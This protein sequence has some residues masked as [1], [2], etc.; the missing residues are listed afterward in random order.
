MYIDKDQWT[1]DDKS[2]NNKFSQIK[3]NQWITPL[4][5]MFEKIR[6]PGRAK[7][8]F[9]YIIFALICLVFVFLG[10][11]I[12]S[13][14]GIGGFAAVVNREGIPIIE[15][16]KR[17][18]QIQKSDQTPPDAKSQKAKLGE[19]SRVVMNQL[20][21]E[22][23]I[24]QQARGSGLA[25]SNHEVR[26]KVTSFELFQ[27][28]GVFKTALYLTFLDNQRLRAKDFEDQMRKWILTSRMERLFH[29]V[30][31]VSDLERE[32]NKELDRVQIQLKYVR[33]ALLNDS[34]VQ[35]WQDLLQ[36]PV[37]LE[38]E[39]KSKKLK[40]IDS[41]KVSLRNWNRALPVAVNEKELFQQVLGVIPH[42]G[43]IPKLFL[44]KNH[45]II[46]SLKNFKISKKKMVQSS[47]ESMDSFLS[48]AYSRM[49][50][51]SWLEFVK[52]QSRIRINT[53]ILNSS[54]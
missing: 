18:D 3:K 16:Q 49:T 47:K 36:E 38:R 35:K 22:A 44:D 32:K 50:F 48:F 27:E 43:L 41:Q 13:L 45:L 14:S 39:L 52:N 28:N 40:W 34:E 5:A 37:L 10:V 51:S 6:K 29:Y 8:F 15:F 2:N 1:N 11:P 20:I 25:V 21:N 33:V 53:K 12:D 9:A 30:F 23:L 7:S 19:H 26:N 46:A 54:N 31:A 24:F 42:R 4:S 17:L